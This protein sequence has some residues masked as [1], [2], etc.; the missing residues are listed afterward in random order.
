MTLPIAEPKEL[1]GVGIRIVNKHY[2]DLLGVYKQTGEIQ[3]GAPVYKNENGKKI[4]FKDNEWH[5]VDF[6]P[7]GSEEVV[8]LKATNKHASS[9]CLATATWSVRLTF[10]D[11]RWVIISPFPVTCNQNSGTYNT[12]K[13]SV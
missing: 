6:F 13:Q 2:I 9:P 4:F 8:G 11:F 7:D 1:D 10:G 12:N 5:A 3:N